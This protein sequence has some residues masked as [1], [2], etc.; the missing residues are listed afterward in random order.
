MPRSIYSRSKRSWLT[1]NQV[2]LN[3]CFKSSGDSCHVRFFCKGKRRPLNIDQ[4]ENWRSALRSFCKI[5][6]TLTKRTWTINHGSYISP[7]STALPTIS[8]AQDSNKPPKVWV[9]L[10]RSSLIEP[11]LDRATWT[12]FNS[13]VSTCS[14]TWLPLSSWAAT[15]KPSPTSCFKSSNKKSLST[16]MSTQGLLR[17]CTINSISLPHSRWLKS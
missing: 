9:C 14:D 8:L 1:S 17:P 5:K 10:V 7:L 15:L 16:Q 12:S 3:S 13:S 2:R 4:S 6:S 11:M